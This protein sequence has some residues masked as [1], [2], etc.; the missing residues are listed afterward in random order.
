M[1][2]AA[3]TAFALLAGL[4]IAVAVALACAT[5]P[6]LLGSPHS[7]IDG[8]D[9]LWPVA[10]LGDWPPPTE[11]LTYRSRVHSEDNWRRREWSAEKDR[12]EKTH[13]QEVHCFGWPFRALRF[14]VQGD[15][16]TYVWQHA[17]KKPPPQ[18]LRPSIA[19]T[20]FPL[21][22]LWPGLLGNTV[23]YSVVLVTPIL[24]ATHV[25]RRLRAR[26]GACLAC[27]Y[28]VNA[29]RRCPEC[30]TERNSCGGAA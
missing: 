22:P 15:A 16:S 28:P 4:G 27:G 23:L 7:Q 12:L 21:S 10:P 8:E 18:F 29:S 17:S 30:G 9:L 3:T 24:G 26:R 13:Y 6:P 14:V 2:R 1:K 25:S 11:R 20:A 5:W 19:A